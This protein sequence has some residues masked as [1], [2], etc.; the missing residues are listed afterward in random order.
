MQ[1]KS[2]TRWV[3][4]L[5]LSLAM[6][7]L[8]VLAEVGDAVGAEDAVAAVAKQTMSLQQIIEAGGFIMYV[9]AG[10]SIL[11]VALVLYFSVVLCRAQVAPRALHRDLIEKIRAGALDDARRACEYR[12][13]PL[14]H[15]V[16]AAV[17]YVRH[18]AN[19]EPT[20][21]RD[22]IEGEG[23]RQSENIQGQT[24]YLLDIAVVAPMIGLLGTVFGMLRAFSAVALDIAQAKPIV[25]AA[26]VSQALITTAFGLIVGIPAM[27]FYAFFRRRAAKVVSC[28][29]A[30]AAEILT[31]MVSKSDA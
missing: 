21:L 25:L 18:V 24:Q 27:V 19:A 30:S 29:E 16:I 5:C 7:P 12:M 6:M 9:L 4:W 2:M 20:M 11:T 1:S 8:A 28:L 15:I 17:E 23:A 10:V 26:G 14:S 31:A 22:V 3:R 13:C